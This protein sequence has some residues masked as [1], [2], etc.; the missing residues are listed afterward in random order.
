M[1]N[2]FQIKQLNKLGLNASKA[3]LIL[4]ILSNYASK[5]PMFLPSIKQKISK[6]T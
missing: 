2:Y 1:P 5:L 4:S 3:L 6:K